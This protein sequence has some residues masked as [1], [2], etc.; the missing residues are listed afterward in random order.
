MLRIQF[1]SVSSSKLYNFEIMLWQIY[2]HLYSG[3]RT[4][5]LRKFLFDIF[6][7]YALHE[8]KKIVYNIMTHA[9]YAS[10]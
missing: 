5:T 10:S 2:Q 6:S 3:D 1:Y 9:I 4:C 8:K 7:F